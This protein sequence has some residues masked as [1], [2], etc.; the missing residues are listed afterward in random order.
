MSYTALSC[1]VT[2][3]DTIYTIFF[4]AANYI[5]TY[6]VFYRAYQLLLLDASPIVQ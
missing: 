5:S 2:K 4:I 1:Y 6:V 3:I